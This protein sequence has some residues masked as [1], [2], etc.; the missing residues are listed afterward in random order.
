M[1]AA[2]WLQQGGKKTQRLIDKQ[3]HPETEEIKK[4]LPN[5]RGFRQVNNLGPED[6]ERIKEFQIEM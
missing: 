6:H 1:R 4:N 3:N 2:A 5:N